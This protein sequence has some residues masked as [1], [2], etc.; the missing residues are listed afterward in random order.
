MKYALQTSGLLFLTIVTGCAAIPNEVDL[1]VQTVPSGAN[2]VS[3]EGWS[4]TTPCT[5]SVTRDSQFILEVTQPGYKPETEQIRIPEIERS[6]MFRNIGAGV[7]FVVMFVGADIS[8]DLGTALI[9]A[10]TGE[11]VSV[12]STGEKIG[13]GLIGGGVFGG[14]GYA[15]DRARDQTRAKQPIEVQIELNNEDNSEN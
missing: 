5:H 3:T 4:C 6:N 10:F 15:I 8:S 7:G 13:A 1:M 9:E 11:K 2:V 14:I 12:L